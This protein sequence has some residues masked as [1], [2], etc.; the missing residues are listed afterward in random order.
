MKDFFSSVP[1][2]ERIK[3]SLGDRI[4]K[5][6][7]NQITNVSGFYKIIES[8]SQLSPERQEELLAIAEF[9]IEQKD[10]DKRDK[11]EWEEWRNVRKLYRELLIEIKTIKP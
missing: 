6:D 2:I 1:K 9:L 8:F 7:P 4:S 11:Q 3:S 10:L 5:I